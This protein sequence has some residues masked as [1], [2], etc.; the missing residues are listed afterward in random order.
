MIKL[1]RNKENK[2]IFQKNINSKK[3][4]E[5]YLKVQD[6]LRK[7]TNKD[8]I[9]EKCKLYDVYTGR[10]K[11]GSLNT[12]GVRLSQMC[13]YMFGHKTNDG[14]FIPTQTTINILNNEKNLSDNMLVQLFAIQFPHPYS[15]TPIGFN[16]Y[17]GRLLLKLLTDERIGCKLYIDEYIWFL[18]FIKKID[19]DTYEE[20]IKS[21]L[22]YR[23]F[24]YEHKLSMFKLVDEY[25][26]VFANCLHEGKYYFMNIFV[27]FGVLKF[28]SD[29]K[30]NEGKIFK[31]KHGNSKTYRTDAIP[32]ENCSGYI[33]L[34]DTLFEKTKKL[35]GKYS[36]FEM[37]KS[38]S[39]SDFYTKES[40]IL[41]L[42]GLDII[43]YLSIVTPTENIKAEII[44]CINNMQ[45]KAVNSS[46]DGKEFEYATEPVME[47][48]DET[49]KAEVISG[50]GDTDI[51]CVMGNKEKNYKINID[52]KKGTG[53]NGTNTK[54]LRKHIEKNNS[55]Y[56]IIIAPRFPK[57]I[58]E[59]IKDEKIVA[60]TAN[61]L[62][63]YCLKECFNNNNYLASFAPINEIAKNHLGE[64]ITKYVKQFIRQKY[65]I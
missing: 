37:P 33:K 9:Q 41:D 1:V 39:N 14:V 56:C 10:S 11:N 36:A 21:I 60:L 43:N 44:N 48:F 30:H 3:L 54:R 50:A 34:E 6:E 45:T 2:W 4:M 20:L 19:I 55:E 59:D 26:N 23:K 38:L 61:C 46:N 52:C 47:L 35:L 22:E 12:M 27:D 49:I 25:E 24:T 31:F 51:L 62:A 63:D 7:T 32:R 40:W 53:I 13:F 28:V 8:I 58:I 17:V 16:I 5:G 15:R 29:N 42:Y 57:G 64:D 18:P 65:G